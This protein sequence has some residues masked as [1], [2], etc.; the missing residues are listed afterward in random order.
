MQTPA[1]TLL[2][3]GLR[4]RSPVGREDLLTRHISSPA[5]NPYSGTSTL[6]SVSSHDHMHMSDAR[7]HKP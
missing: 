6:A 1:Q 2:L 4:G 3:L 5:M 7:C